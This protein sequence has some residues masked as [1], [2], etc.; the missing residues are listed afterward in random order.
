LAFGVCLNFIGLNL[1]WELQALRSFYSTRSVLC[2]M[3]ADQAAAGLFIPCPQSGDAMTWIV[4]GDAEKC[5]S[6]FTS[7]D[8]GGSSTFA[9]IGAFAAEA[10]V[11]AQTRTLD[12]PSIW[13]L[14]EEDLSSLPTET[15]SSLL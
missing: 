6:S 11:T 8:R 5:N 7:K 15:P 12:F 14:H 13:V 1:F 4:G 9:S 3:E 10:E 2:A